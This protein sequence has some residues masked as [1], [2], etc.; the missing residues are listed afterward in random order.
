MFH[1]WLRVTGPKLT[2][3][4]LCSNVFCMYVYIHS[5]CS[6]IDVQRFTDDR[7]YRCS[8]VLQLCR[9]VCGESNVMF[10]KRLLTHHAYLPTYL[11]NYVH[12][13]MQYRYKSWLLYIVSANLRM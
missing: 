8:S 3:A 1:K 7:S 5:L 10:S 2:Y 9:S 13:Y 12:M 6:G 11:H 4:I